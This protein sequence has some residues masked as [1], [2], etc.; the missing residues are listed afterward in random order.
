M[1]ARFLLEG[2]RGWREH[3]GFLGRRPAGD[4]FPPYQIR[5]ARL[6]RGRA[7]AAGQQA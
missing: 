3:G 6:H 5:G 4:A 1:A 2:K 7:H